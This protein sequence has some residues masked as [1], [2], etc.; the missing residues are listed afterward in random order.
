MIIL[1]AL[2]ILFW[3]ILIPFCIGFLPIRIIPTG[4]RK[5]IF[6]YITGFIITLAALELTGIPTEL[7]FVYN[8]YRKFV[9]VFGAVLILLAVFGVISLRA[10]LTA[11]SQKL[12]CTSVKSLLRP[13]KTS[14]KSQ[15]SSMS[16]ESKIYMLISLLLIA[17]QIVMLFLVY[18]RDADDSFYNAQATSAQ[19]FGTMYRIDAGTG[20]TTNL[21]YRHCFALFPMYQAFISS[22]SGVHLLIVAHKIVPIVLIPI[23]YY[24]LYNFG[25]VLFPKKQEA[26]WLFVILI[27]VFKL[28]GGISHYTAETFFLLRTW[29]GKSFAGNFILP[30][31][32]FIFLYMKNKSDGTVENNAKSKSVNKFE[33]LA[34]AFLVLAAGSASSIAVLISVGLVGLLSL[35]FLV[36]NRDWKAFF[37]EIATIIPGILYM[38][39]YLIC[40]VVG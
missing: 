17:S 30:G 37:R 18:S 25:S 12:N 20:Y 27:N 11:S 10:F 22:A 28:F 23:T 14:L 32:I 15:I 1:N 7:I 34:L 19:V 21:D 6:I 26:A 36:I 5:P 24:L 39:L 38:L 35:I 2:G 4:L 3:M 9:I 16:L 8:A 40:T 13:E 31:I 33:L 29:Q